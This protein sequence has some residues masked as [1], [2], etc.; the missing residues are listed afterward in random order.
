MLQVLSVNAPIAI[1]AFN[2]IFVPQIL[3][4]KNLMKRNKEHAE[5]GAP[6]TPNSAIGLPFILVNTSKNTVIDCSIS[7]DK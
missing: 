5:S 6:P 4:L 7:S 1:N 2:F 3:T